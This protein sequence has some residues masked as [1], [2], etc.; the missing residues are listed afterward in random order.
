MFGAVWAKLINPAKLRHSSTNSYALTRGFMRSRFWFRFLLSIGCVAGLASP[1]LA[2]PPHLEVQTTTIEVVP[3]PDK[4]VHT[5]TDL[6]LIRLQLA[7]MARLS[8]QTTIKAVAPAAP[9]PAATPTAPGTEVEAEEVEADEPE[10]TE[11]VET[12]EAE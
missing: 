10:E 4:P 7:E 2:E 11:E 9:K 1:S 12:E 5:E 8:P 3:L 6:G